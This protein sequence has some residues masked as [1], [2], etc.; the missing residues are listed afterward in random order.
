MWLTFD[1]WPNMGLEW[2]W[3]VFRGQWGKKQ[4]QEFEREIK[5]AQTDC[6]ISSLI[7]SQR[8]RN[9]GKANTE[10]SLGLE[11]G[12]WGVVGPEE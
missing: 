11:G 3:F 10:K 7:L 5:L 6:V 4:A 1:A 8:N 12:V 9:E 2:N